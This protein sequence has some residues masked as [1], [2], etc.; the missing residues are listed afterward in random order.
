MVM[1]GPWFGL[2]GEWSGELGVLLSDP[3]LGRLT[4]LV[5]PPRTSTPG[6]AGD[7]VGALPAPPGPGVEEIPSWTFLLGS[8]P[9]PVPVLPAPEPVEF[10]PLPEPSP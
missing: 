8:V 4:T 1:A 7:P 10:K 9:T 6:T 2:A 5:L 3:K